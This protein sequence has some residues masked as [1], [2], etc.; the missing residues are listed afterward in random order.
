MGMFDYVTGLPE[1]LC[2]TCGS[3]LGG[4]QTKDGDACL[5]EVD[6]RTLEN[7]YTSCDGLV[8]G[9]RCA[10]WVEFTRTAPPIPPAASLDEF[11][12]TIK[13]NN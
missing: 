1:I 10:T 4:W 5:D 12:K 11:N 13:E 3:K 2:P 9:H 8:D 7:F 6:W